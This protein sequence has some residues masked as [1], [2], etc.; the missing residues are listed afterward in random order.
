VEDQKSI[1]LP[2]ICVGE[3]C[4]EGED[5]QTF[6]D[7]L[8]QKYTDLNEHIQSMEK[9][10]KDTLGEDRTLKKRLQDIDDM[11]SEGVNK[12][13]DEMRQISIA[14][15]KIVKDFEEKITKLEKDRK[16]ASETINSLIKKQ[17]R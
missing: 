13:E 16:K 10:L 17:I 9:A 4:I 12:I 11:R 2:K 15:R 3:F 8:R 7:S 6:V 14:R 5:I 1:L